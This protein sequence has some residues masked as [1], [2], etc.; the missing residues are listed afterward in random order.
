M[1]LLVIKQPHALALLPILVCVVSKGL[2]VR[3]RALRPATE[4]R[5]RRYRSAPGTV[6]SGR[7]SPE[8]RGQVGALLRRQ[9][10]PAPRRGHR[11]LG[12]CFSAPPDAHETAASHRHPCF[13]SPGFY[14]A[15]AILLGALFRKFPI[16]QCHVM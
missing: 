16:T 11:D 2:I 10:A 12:R 3:R 5:W 7:D 4:D 6:A 15:C 8:E 13:D 9:A 14:Y 1:H